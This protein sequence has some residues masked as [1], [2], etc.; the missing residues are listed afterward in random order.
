MIVILKSDYSLRKAHRTKTC[1]LLNFLSGLRVF[2]YFFH[3]HQKV[4][5]QG[6]DS[7][8]VCS[9]VHLLVLKETKRIVMVQYSINSHKAYDITDPNSKR[10]LCLIR[11]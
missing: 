1:L 5:I 3:F 7:W 9:V 10:V 4:I 11:T 8:C 6:Q 2:F